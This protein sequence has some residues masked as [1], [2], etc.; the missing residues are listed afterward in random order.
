MQAAD[1]AEIY[2]N[3]AAG[4]PPQAVA[5]LENGSLV[6]LKDKVP[7]WIRNKL[8]RPTARK[9]IAVVSRSGAPYELNVRIKDI[10]LPESIRKTA[11]RVRVAIRKLTGKRGADS[12]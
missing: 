8:L 11:S 4:G 10:Q 7:A 2:D 5:K 6:V 9:G 12:S 1:K 3:S